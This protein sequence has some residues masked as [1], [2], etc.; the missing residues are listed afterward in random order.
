MIIIIIIS[1]SNSN[2]SSS[3]NNNSSYSRGSDSS[4]SRSN[5]SSKCF[6]QSQRDIYTYL[7]YFMSN[8]VTIPRSVNDL[9]Y[10]Q[11]VYA[12]INKYRNLHFNY[13]RIRDTYTTISYHSVREKSNSS[14]FHFLPSLF[15]FSLLKIYPYIQSV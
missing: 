11:I 14:A 8:N 15:R 7:V 10:T 1:S 2:S 5:S 12:N 9:Y 3:S 13:L 6:Q 4:S